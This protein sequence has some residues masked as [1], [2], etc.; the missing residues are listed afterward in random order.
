M[1]LLKRV[2]SLFFLL[3]GI[4]LAQAIHANSEST[5]HQRQQIRLKA[6]QHRIT[7]QVRLGI[8]KPGGA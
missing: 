7:V 3:K 2:A 5:V 4:Q 6:G 8:Q 1:S